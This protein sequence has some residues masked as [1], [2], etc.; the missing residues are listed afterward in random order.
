[1][2][3]ATV[4]NHSL[5]PKRRIKF[6]VGVTYG[7]TRDQVRAAVERIEAYLRGN[8]D[9]DQEF[10]LVKFTEFN[11]SSLDIFVYCFTVTTDWTEHLSVKQT[12]NLKVMEILESLGMEIAFP[13]RTVH[14]ETDAAASGDPAGD[15]P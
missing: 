11:E 7:S 1:M 14:L 12:V 9:I 15:A 6:T 5:M 3:N 4:E 13:T 2:A 10:M 8:P